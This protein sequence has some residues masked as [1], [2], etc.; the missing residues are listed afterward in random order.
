M[1]HADSAKAVL[2]NGNMSPRGSSHAGGS[3][4]NTLAQLPLVTGSH[5]RRLESKSSSGETLTK[6]T[7]NTMC[8]GPK[9]KSPMS[10]SPQQDNGGYQVGAGPGWGQNDSQDLGAGRAGKTVHSAQVEPAVSLGN[11]PNLKGLNLLQSGFS[12]ENWCDTPP[13]DPNEDAHVAITIGCAMALTKTTNR[14]EAASAQA[15]KRGPQVRVEEIPDDE[16]DTS[17]Q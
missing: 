5:T 2:H 3:E 10:A 16:D 6:D 14:K 13:G 17:F 9:T 8:S 11:G 7:L 1:Q 15:V 4:V 12:N